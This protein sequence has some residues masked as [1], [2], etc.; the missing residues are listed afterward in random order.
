LVPAEAIA[1]LRHTDNLEAAVQHAVAV[2]TDEREII[3]CS[4]STTL[5]SFAEWVAVMRFGEPLSEGAVGR[6]EV[7]AADIA[8]EAPTVLPQ[9]H[10]L[11]SPNECPVTFAPQV[12][13]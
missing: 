11:E 4:D 7:E 13:A 5:G 9:P 12:Q 3:E 2:R 10:F 6:N 8:R 1:Q